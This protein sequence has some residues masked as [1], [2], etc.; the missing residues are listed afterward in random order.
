MTVVGA[1]RNYVLAC[2]RDGAEV[3]VF[4]KQAL[5]GLC[6]HLQLASTRKGKLITTNSTQGWFCSSEWASPKGSL[7]NTI[8]HSTFVGV[9]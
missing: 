5:E 9:E 2:L 7:A 3:V 1:V 4:G 8:S 6:P